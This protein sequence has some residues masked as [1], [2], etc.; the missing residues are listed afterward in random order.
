MSIPLFSPQ[1]REKK[2]MITF[3]E[4]FGPRFTL[5]G[6]QLLTVSCLGRKCDVTF[7]KNEPAID[8]TV[9]QRL[10][11]ALCCGVG[12]EMFYK[13]LQDIRLSNGAVVQ[14]SDIWTI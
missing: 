14:M 11:L 12:P 5:L 2:S 7:F 1:R 6:R 8:V 4:I 3:E 13:M 9:D 10:G